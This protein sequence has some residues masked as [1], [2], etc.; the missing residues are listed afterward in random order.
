MF[1]RWSARI[2]L[3]IGVWVLGAYLVHE[4]KGVVYGGTDSRP[5]YYSSSGGGG[6]GFFSGGGY[7]GGK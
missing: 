3:V 2:Y 5:S 6:V 7:G 1:K 4:R